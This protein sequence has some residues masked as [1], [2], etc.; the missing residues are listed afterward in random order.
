VRTLSALRTGPTAAMEGWYRGAYMNP[1]PTSCTHCATPSGP[2]GRARNTQRRVVQVFGARGSGWRG[3]R[4]QGAGSRVRRWS[5]SCAPE[6]QLCVP[7]PP[8]RSTA[9]PSASSTSADPHSD[10]TERFPCFA[11]LA[12][13]AAARMH[14]PVE[15]LT[16]PA[17]SP[18]V[19]T[20]SNTSSPA[21][22]CTERAC[23]ALH[24]EI[25]C[26]QP[27]GRRVVEGSG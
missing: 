8:P 5:A 15:M 22:T 23:I 21:K 20:M 14:E 18:P 10:E 27:V 16:V 13:A 17:S 11:T 24:A 4:A 12:P 9:T 19:P 26:N 25:Q 3:S 1:M 2:R 7:R 6:A